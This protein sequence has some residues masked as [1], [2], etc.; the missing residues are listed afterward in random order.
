MHNFE[1]KPGLEYQFIILLAKILTSLNFSFL[2]CKMGK[3][4][5]RLLVELEN[6]WQIVLG[7]I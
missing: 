2:N 1:I 7:I 6:G 5:A 3:C 4:Y